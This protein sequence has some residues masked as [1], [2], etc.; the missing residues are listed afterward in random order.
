[1]EWLPE[2]SEFDVRYSNEEDLPDLMRWMQDPEVQRWY[3]ISSQK[4]MEE[5]TKNWIGFSRFGASLTATYKGDPI[6]IATLFLMPY[7]KTIH[8]C[9]IYFI[10]HPDYR[11]KGVGTAIL[12]N[13]V[14]LGKTYFRLERIHVEVYEGCPAIRLLKKEHF[15]EVARQER[16]IK[17]P[18]GQYLTRIIY[19]IESE[20][21]NGK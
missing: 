20:K 9:L 7:K 8:H 16:Y 5:M 19:E 10:V 1:M 4:N 18:N 15:H 2:Q 11:G 3:P 6:A 21:F 17:E 13:I 12:R 14:H